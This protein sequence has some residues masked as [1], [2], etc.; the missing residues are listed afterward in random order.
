MPSCEPDGAR[1]AAPN[2]S[3]PQGPAAAR[4]QELCRSWLLGLCTRGDRCTYAHGQAP[5]PRGGPNS[6]LCRTWLSQGN[7]RNRRCRFAHSLAELRGGGPELPERSPPGEAGEAPPEAAAEAEAAGAA[8]GGE[9]AAQ[10]PPAWGPQAAG[11]PALVHHY[12]L[13][14]PRPLSPVPEGSNSNSN[15]NHNGANGSSNSN[16]NHNGANGG[17][18]AAR[19]GGHRTRPPAGPPGAAT[20]SGSAARSRP[21]RTQIN[22]TFNLWG[23]ESMSMGDLASRAIQLQA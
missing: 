20:A 13:A 5:L 2:G 22:I 9:E 7:C 12:E 23:R 15:S 18:H 4:S 6:S 16:S 14:G 19:A 8:A 21:P 10:A 3:S 17:S 1:A 11:T